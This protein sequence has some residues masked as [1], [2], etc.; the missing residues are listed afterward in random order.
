MQAVKDGGIV[1]GNNGGLA[2]G[3]SHFGFLSFFFRRIA[4]HTSIGRV[5]SKRFL[6]FGGRCLGIVQSIKDGGSS[7]T[8][9]TAA[10]GGWF[11]LALTSLWSWS[12]DTPVTLDCLIWN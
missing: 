8:T 5:L 9:T 12:F 10:R 4:P 2:G 7:L 3:S 11:C 6:A 1:F